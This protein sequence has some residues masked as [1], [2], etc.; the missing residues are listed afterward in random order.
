MFDTT[1][2]VKNKLLEK[3]RSFSTY[4]VDE[5][6]YVFQPKDNLIPGIT[7]DQF[8]DDLCEGSG[9]ELRKKLCA[10]QSSSALAVN[11]FAHWKRNP[12]TLTLK[13]DE[14]QVYFLSIH[15]GSLPPLYQQGNL[16]SINFS[17]QLDGQSMAR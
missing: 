4:T 12:H 10:I 8:K 13:Q 16:L 17:S 2:T 11:T 9:D 5:K 14:G 7:M 3:F 1:K 6:G 15:Q